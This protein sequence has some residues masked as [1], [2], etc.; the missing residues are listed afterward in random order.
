MILVR[1]VT[2]DKAPMHGIAVYCGRPT[3]LGNP[4]TVG[5]DGTRKQVIAKFAHWF[6]GM[7]ASHERTPARR[8]LRQLEILSARYQFDEDEHLFLL[9]WCYPDDCHC[10]VIKEYLEK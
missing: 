7:V 4:F 8:L 5:K 1:K 10:D 9:C 3:P 6:D 2:G